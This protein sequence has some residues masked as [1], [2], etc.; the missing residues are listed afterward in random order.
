MDL[1]Q[2]SDTTETDKAGAKV[3]TIRP[4]SAGMIPLATNHSIPGTPKPKPIVKLNLWERILMV[5][6][7]KGHKSS[8]PKGGKGGKKK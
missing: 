1:S 4:Y 2:Y 6:H 5:L 7:G 3:R 8:K